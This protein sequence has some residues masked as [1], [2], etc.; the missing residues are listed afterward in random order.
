M[1]KIPLKIHQ[2]WYQGESNVP[3]HLQAYRQSW[4]DI[5]P[6]YSFVLWDKDSIET[7]IKGFPPAIS[8]LYYSYELMIQRI[9]FAKYVILY[10][11]G[12]IYIDMDVKCLQSLDTIYKKHPDKNVILSLCPY[13]FLHSLS[14][15][16]VGLRLNENLINNGVIACTPRH[17]FLLNI[18]RQAETN[19]PTV[20]KAV[21]SFLHIFYTT[22]PVM[23]THAFRNTKRREDIVVLD[24]TYFEACDID[25]V[26]N[27]CIPPSHAVALHVYEGSWHSSSEKSVVNMYFFMERN[28]KTLLFILFI[29]YIIFR[30]PTNKRR[31]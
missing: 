24:N 17:S 3:P 5:H 15:G 1:S 2:I 4:I 31:L 14:L 21:S 8:T 11:Y 22:G 7:L 27:G 13:N 18:I 19:R 16:L 25:S 26:K 30:T 29:M 12:G 6:N 20:F 10:A 28:S 23:V 9:D